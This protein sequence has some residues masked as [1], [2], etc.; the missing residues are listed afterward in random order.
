VKVT[1]EDDDLDEDEDGK[2]SNRRY[3]TSDVDRR[4]EHFKGKLFDVLFS[5]QKQGQGRIQ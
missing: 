2:A 3:S 1:S 4:R 5:E